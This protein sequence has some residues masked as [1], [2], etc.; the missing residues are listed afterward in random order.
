MVT[1]YRVALL[2]AA[3]GRTVPANRLTNEI[4]E[5][6]CMNCNRRIQVAGLIALGFSPKEARAKT[7]SE[8]A[9]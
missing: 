8:E 2:K 3:C 5:T 9:G 6:N 4:G 1:H 7:K